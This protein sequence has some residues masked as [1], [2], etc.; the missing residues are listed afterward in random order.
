MTVVNDFF[1]RNQLSQ[2]L[3]KINPLAEITHK[4]RVT[5]IV[6]EKKRAGFEVRDVHYTH[7]GRLCPI[8]TP[9]GAN[10]GLINSLT[11]YSQIDNFGFIKTPYFKVDQGKVTNTIEYFSADKE[12][13]FIIAPP[14]T[15]IDQTTNMIIPK[16]LTVR[17][18]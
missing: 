18:E 6:R 16:E 3:D 11:V 17:T 1:A 14:D 5:A 7:F 2:F 9:E 4:R 8:E 15:P 13:E 12:D 10:I